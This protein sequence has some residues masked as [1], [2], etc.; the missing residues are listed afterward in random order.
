MRVRNLK[1]GYIWLNRY[2]KRW[3]LWSAKKKR[4]ILTGLI[5]CSFIQCLRHKH[6]RFGLGFIY[7][8]YDLLTLHRETEIKRS[9]P[10]DI[11]QS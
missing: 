5:L 2:R 7:S 11:A 4:A 1:P 3:G 8:F 6:L 9:R 10:A